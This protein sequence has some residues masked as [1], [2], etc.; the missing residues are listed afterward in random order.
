M[1]WEGLEPS[2]FCFVD[3]LYVVYETDATTDCATKA[4]DRMEVIGVYRQLDVLVVW[5]FKEFA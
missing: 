3:T 2:T 1:P 4:I 5:L